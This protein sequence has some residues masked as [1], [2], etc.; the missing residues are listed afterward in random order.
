MG[1]AGF[2]ADWEQAAGAEYDGY[3]AQPVAA[4]I[5]AARA[6]RYGE[7]YQLW[8]AIGTRATPAEAGWT[9]LEVLRRDDPYL[10]RYH[11]AGALLALLG[12]QELEPVDLAAERPGRA[13]NLDAVV[14]ILRERLIADGAT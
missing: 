14:R 3:V 11:A 1:Y 13:A 9:L 6:G 2:Q 12:P 5:E 7:Y 8:R 10:V 4:L